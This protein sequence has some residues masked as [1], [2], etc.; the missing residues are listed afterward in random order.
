MLPSKNN[1]FG[2]PGINE[3]KDSTD[4]IVLCNVGALPV[5]IAPMFD[6]TLAPA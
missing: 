2:T 6:T 3:P 1:C 5:T 4:D